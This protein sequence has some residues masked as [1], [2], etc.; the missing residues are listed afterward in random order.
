ML[1]KIVEGENTNIVDIIKRVNSIQSE[2]VIYPLK[3]GFELNRIRIEGTGYFAE[4]ESLDKLIR[5]VDLFSYEYEVR[6]ET[7]T[8]GYKQIIKCDPS[9]RE[10]LDAPVITISAKR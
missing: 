8:E 2:I 10:Y 7:V 5:L 9:L 4:L 1:F 3:Y 6:I